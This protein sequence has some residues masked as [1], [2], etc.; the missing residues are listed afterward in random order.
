MDGVAQS[1]VYN[2]PLV[3]TVCKFE[4]FLFNLLPHFPCFVSLWCDLTSAC[5][6]SDQITSISHCVVW[7]VCDNEE[8]VVWQLIHVHFS[9]MGSKAIITPY[10]SIRTYSKTGLICMYGTWVSTYSTW[11]STCC[12]WVSTYSTRSKIRHAQCIEIFIFLLKLNRIYQICLPWRKIEF[13]D[14]N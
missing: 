6:L 14:G 10:F 13:L 8:F 11:V 4:S 7:M 5:P 9:T 3:C 2:R 12:T 1:T